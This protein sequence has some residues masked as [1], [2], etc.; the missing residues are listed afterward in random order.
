M[1]DGLFITLEGKDGTGKS[2]QLRQA[3]VGIPFRRKL[4]GC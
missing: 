2:T 3:P 1:R 4:I